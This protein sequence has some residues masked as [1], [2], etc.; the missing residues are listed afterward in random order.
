M[1]FHKDEFSYKGII[2]GELSGGEIF[3]DLK[4]G[5]FFLVMG[6]PKSIIHLNIQHYRLQSLTWGSTFNST[7]RR[8]EPLMSRASSLTTDQ[9]ITNQL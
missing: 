4:S 5:V 1:R 2:R 7:T 3:G 9:S 6:Y 8:L